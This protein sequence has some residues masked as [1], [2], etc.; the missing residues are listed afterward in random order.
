MLLDYLA[1]LEAEKKELTRMI[2]EYDAEIIALRNQ[3]NINEELIKNYSELRSQAAAA[4]GLVDMAKLGIDKA[5][6]R[7]KEAMDNVNSIYTSYQEDK[8]K[9]MEYPIVLSGEDEN[10]IQLSDYFKTKTK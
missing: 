8:K 6:K 5:I 3:K 10:L 4:R 2:S 9:V 1:K 7:A